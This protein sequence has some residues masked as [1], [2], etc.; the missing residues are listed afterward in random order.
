MFS[1]YHHFTDSKA[2]LFVSLYFVFCVLMMV[3]QCSHLHYFVTTG[4]G[5]AW[6]CSPQS[7]ARYGVTEH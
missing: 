3:P 7:Q 4:H 5:M 1:G 6:L 2:E